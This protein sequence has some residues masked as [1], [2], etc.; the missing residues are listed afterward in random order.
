MNRETVPV[1]AQKENAQALGRFRAE[2]GVRAESNMRG[3]SSRQPGF[4]GRR[5]AAA[6]TS[7]ALRMLRLKSRPPAREGGLS[8]GA[9]L[10][11]RPRSRLRRDLGPLRRGY[12]GQ[13]VPRV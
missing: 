11:R 10:P 2:A 7:R 4:A 8:P 12:G 6:L 13:G 3:G 9:A 1:K 5:F